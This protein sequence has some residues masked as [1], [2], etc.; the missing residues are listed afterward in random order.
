MDYILNDEE[1][2]VLGSLM[3]KEMATPDHYPLSL[4]ALTNA[5]N[6]KSNRDPVV[7][8]DEETVLQAL[9][10]LKEKRLVVQSHAGRVAKYSENFIK[11]NDLSIRQAALLCLLLLRG[12]QTI[13]EL[14]GRSERLRRFEELGEVERVLESLAELD[15]VTRLPKQPGRKEARYAH[16]LAGEARMA[17]ESEP[18]AEA[19]FVSRSSDRERIAGLEQEVD[20]LKEELSVLRREFAE[21]RQLLE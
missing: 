15:M 19:V 1:I 12:P 9:A 2:R 10:S 18:E 13:G 11:I 4:N 17:E 7:S 3:E 21:F 8:Y 5:C 6:Q 20:R 14:R 16:L